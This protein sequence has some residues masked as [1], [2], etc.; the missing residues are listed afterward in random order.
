MCKNG[1]W[2]A[3]AA[4]RRSDGDLDTTTSASRYSLSDGGCSTSG[5][6]QRPPLL[7]SGIVS[8]PRA[9]RKRGRHNA[10]KGQQPLFELAAV[11][12]RDQDIRRAQTGRILLRRPVAALALVPRPAVLFLAGALAGAI[13]KTLTAPLDRVKI[14]LQV[15]EICTCVGLVQQCGTF[16]YGFC[17]EGISKKMSASGSLVALQPRFPTAFL[18]LVVKYVQNVSYEFL[19]NPVA[20]C[21]HAICYYLF[22]YNTQE[23][24]EA[25][26]DHS[27][28][29]PTGQGRYGKFSCADCGC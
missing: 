5:R 21:G 24:W 18:Q 19:I 9:T 26:S 2:R 1:E 15:Q 12:D 16:L 27:F 25:G 3:L 13:G 6:T 22:A 20:L 14:L 23:V 4:R 11:D 29:R 28:L 10:G 7:S 8:I 17:K